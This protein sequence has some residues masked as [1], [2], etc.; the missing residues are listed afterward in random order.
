MS[1]TEL[2]LFG[3]AV[4]AVLLVIWLLRSRGNTSGTHID[5]SMTALGAATEAVEDV[6]EKVVETVKESFAPEEKLVEER[7]EI[8]TP[9]PEPVKTPV[10][11]P[12]AGGAPNNLRLIKGLGP[13]ANTL[14]NELG[15]T[16]F[17]QIAAWSDEDVARIDANMGSFKGRI[18]RDNWVEQAGYLASGDTAGFEAKFGKLDGAA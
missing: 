5:T 6:A 2:L 7:A 8:A 18:V 4:L 16:R 12:A 3:L 11:V 15:I 17:D 10:G 9:R 14:L 1:T 13:K